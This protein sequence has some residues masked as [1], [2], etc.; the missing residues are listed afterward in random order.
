MLK[1]RFLVLLGLVLGFCVNAPVIALEGWK[2]KQQ[3]LKEFGID[4]GKNHI[5]K[6]VINYAFHRAFILKYVDFLWKDIRENR[7]VFTEVLKRKIAAPVNYSEELQRYIDGNHAY[8]DSFGSC[9]KCLGPIAFAMIAN[10]I[11]RAVTGARGTPLMAISNDDLKSAVTMVATWNID[12]VEH[13]AWFGYTLQTDGLVRN[14]AERAVVVLG[15]LALKWLGTADI[16][17]PKSKK[18]ESEEYQE[19]GKTLNTR[20]DILNKI[21]GLTVDAVSDYLNIKTFSKFCKDKW[22]EH[23]RDHTED[24]YLLLEMYDDAFIENDEEKVLE[25]E[26]N[27][28]KNIEAAI[29][30]YLFIRHISL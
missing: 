29:S 21:L 8:V 22:F 5:P 10:L 20:L 23:L 11:H 25:A 28:K 7:K 30:N 4:F 24:F 27:I 17:A 19:Y 12:I 2:P 13:A 26:N 3:S 15:A 16:D 9:Q 1:K 6:Y 18:K 14:V